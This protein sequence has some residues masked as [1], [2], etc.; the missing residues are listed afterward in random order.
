M[1]DQR[2]KKG[3]KRE[4]KGEARG[5]QVNRLMPLAITQDVLEVPV[6]SRE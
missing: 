4:E 5:R 2:E 3:G 6:K 1:G